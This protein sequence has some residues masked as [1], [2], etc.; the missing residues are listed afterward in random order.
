MPRGVHPDDLALYQ[1]RLKRCGMCDIVKTFDDFNVSGQ[2]SD[3]SKRRSRCIL[4]KRKES[5]SEYERLRL[6]ALRK[7]SVT[8][9]PSC[10]CC[11]ETIV[12]FLGIDHI[13]GGGGK[14]RKEVGT[15]WGFYRWLRRNDFP[16]GFQTMCFNCNQAKHT[17]G[18]CPHQVAL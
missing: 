1:Q 16:E 18:I 11:S 12:Q 4:C 5:K 15:G 17:C 10:A 3:Y 9:Y 7:Y 13:N 14:H 6:E 2:V 8:P